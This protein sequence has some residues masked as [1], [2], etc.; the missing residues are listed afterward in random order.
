ME[1][2]NTPAAVLAAE[3]RRLASDLQAR[4]RDASKRKTAD[5]LHAAIDR[6]R[7][8]AEGAHGESNTGDVW[9]KHDDDLRYVRRV[10]EAGRSMTEEDQRAAIDIV[11]TLRTTARSHAE[12]SS[13]KD[14]LTPEAPAAVAPDRRGKDAAFLAALAR[15]QA[16]EIEHLCKNGY[17]FHTDN[18]K[19]LA[20]TLREAAALL[21]TPPAST[22][23]AMGAEGWRLI[24][25]AP[26][27]GRT[28]LLGA[29]N[30]IGKWRTMRGQ[31]YSRS[32]I[33]GEFE[34]PDDCE[35]GWYETAVEPDETPNCWRTTPTHWQPLP[36]PPSVATS[37]E[38]S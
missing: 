30:R 26:K 17:T 32:V 33:D 36:T 19:P 25:T 34:N 28:I 14:S 13:V 16:G 4:S 8:M 38:E 20:C 31:W 12:E 29:P 11:H 10:L 9:I 35:E 7:E 22:D 2:Q 15:Q 23:R 27:D 5:D 37:A 1:N 21:A 6:L 24:E 3:A 18:L